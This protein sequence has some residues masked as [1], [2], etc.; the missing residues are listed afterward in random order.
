MANML[1]DFAYLFT[2]SPSQP[3]QGGR[4][5][6]RFS[7]LA[8]SWSTSGIGCNR[9]WTALENKRSNSGET[10]LP[11]AMIKKR[12]AMRRAMKRR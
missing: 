7:P 8:C 3:S 9:D 2:G 10:D 11:L 6:I 4:K 5:L 12:R 1:A